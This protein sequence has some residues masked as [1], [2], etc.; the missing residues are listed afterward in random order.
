MVNYTI[1]SNFKGLA[2]AKRRPEA[3]IGSGEMMVSA[4]RM[5]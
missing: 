3:E 4:K 1:W 5:K 2:A